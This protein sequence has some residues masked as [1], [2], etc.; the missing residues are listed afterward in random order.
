MGIK[1]I[2]CKQVCMGTFFDNPALIQNNNLLCPLSDGQAVGDENQGLV[3]SHKIIHDPLLCQNI[4]TTSCLIQNQDR[5][6]RQRARARAILCRC[7][8]EIP[9]PSEVNSVW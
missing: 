8:P 4:Q 6:I 2:L 9:A 5:R 3:Q 7:P 1:A